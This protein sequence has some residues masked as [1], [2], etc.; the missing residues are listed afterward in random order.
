M[1][2][3]SQKGRVIR[4]GFQFVIPITIALISSIIVG[5]IYLHD[6]FRGSPMNREIL[7]ATDISLSLTTLERVVRGDVWI[8]STY[9]ENVEITA[10]VYFAFLD[11]EPSS[12]IVTAIS[13]VKNA[14]YGWVE[15]YTIGVHM[16]NSLPVEK[17]YGE[18]FLEYR[19]DMYAIAFVRLECSAKSIYFGT[20]HM[21]SEIA[22]TPYV[23]SD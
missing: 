6:T 16:L 10:I 21:Y 23:F 17:D 4:G 20:E 22:T 11:Y 3:L 15:S 2:K 9:P 12:D 8:A 5:A 7:D 13:Q 1:T 18:A 19:P 14:K